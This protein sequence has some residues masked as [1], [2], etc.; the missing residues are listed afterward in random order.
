MEQSVP[1]LKTKGGRIG[2]ATLAIAIV[3]GVALQMMA[4]GHNMLVAMCLLLM[5]LMTGGILAIGLLMESHPSNAFWMVLA[6]P[7]LA[8][9]YYLYFML[10]KDLLF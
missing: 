2:L 1:V 8:Q 6:L 4:P 10:S 7:V 9:L 5:V 3:G